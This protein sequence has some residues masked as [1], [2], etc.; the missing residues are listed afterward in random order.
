MVGENGA[1]KTNLLEAVHVATQGFSP[2]PHAEAGLVRFGEAAATVGLEVV[3]GRVAHAIGLRLVPGEAR[4]IE[5][6][7]ARLASTEPLRRRFPALVFT[8]DRLAVVKAGPSARR[9]YLDR[10]LARLE[11]ARAPLPREYAATLVQ[12]NAA[13]RRVQAGVSA[14]E[15][16]RPWSERLAGLGAELVA[17]RRRTLARLADPFAERAA[18]LG[19]A[20]ATLAYEG[21][22]PSV[23]VLEAR[24][25]AD[26]ARGATGRGPHLDDVRIAAAGRDL[27]RFGSQ[28]E[29]RIALLALILA[30]ADLVVPPPLLLLDDVLSELDARRRAALARRIE[31]LEQTLVTATQ[32]AALPLEPAQV[33]EVTPGQA[34]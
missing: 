1:G 3:Q 32:Q 29:Q 19:L 20:G 34:R 18:E 2:R 16:L 26:V 22:A 13:L 24:L 25:A 4:G 33:V 17:A 28:G 11:P 21:D 8:P 9:A 23:A 12:R 15:A 30:E 14:P 6:D 7:G 27:R 5:L 10:A 31:R